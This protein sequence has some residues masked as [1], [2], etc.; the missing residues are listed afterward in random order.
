MRNFQRKFLMRL[1]PLRFLP[2][3]SVSEQDTYTLAASALTRC[4]IYSFLIAASGLSFI[5]LLAG[6]NPATIPTSMANPMDRSANQ[7]GM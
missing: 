7:K 1:V 5:A 2:S 3:E 6:K 4:I